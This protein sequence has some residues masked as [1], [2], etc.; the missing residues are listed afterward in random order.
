[1][2][3]RPKRPKRRT[4]ANDIDRGSIEAFKYNDAAA[5]DKVIIIEPVVKAAYVADT[6]LES[7]GKYIKVTGTAYTLKLLGRAYS[8]AKTYQKGDVVTSGGFVYSAR[9]NAI[10]GA[11]DAAKWKKEIADTIGPVTI[12][13][14]ATICTGRWHN[15]I[16]QAGF[17]VEDDTD[18]SLN[19]IRD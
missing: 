1:M 19:S 18:I 14:G 4:G 17:L 12:V 6:P 11:F 16:G 10:T 9:E 5:A 3:V 13:A 8:A 15:A 2:A 7:T